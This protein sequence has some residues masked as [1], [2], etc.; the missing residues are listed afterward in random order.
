MLVTNTSGFEHIYYDKSRKSWVYDIRQNKQ[1][2]KY[3]F[4]GNYNDKSVLN[5]A[6]EYKKQ[7]ELKLKS[8]TI[9]KNASRTN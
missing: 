2:H 1:C 7:Y 9:N 8:K 6:I 4:P 3:R 5:R